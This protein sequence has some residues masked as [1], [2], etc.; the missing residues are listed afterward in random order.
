MLEALNKFAGFRS[1]PSL[2]RKLAQVLRNTSSEEI[3]KLVERAS[4]NDLHDIMAIVEDLTNH[5]TFFSGI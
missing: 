2:E 1:T 5:E 3:R 4:S